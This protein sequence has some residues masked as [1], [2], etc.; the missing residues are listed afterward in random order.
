MT[1]IVTHKKDSNGFTL[2]LG[3]SAYRKQSAADNSLVT[4]KLCIKKIAP[5]Y[6]MAMEAVSKVFSALLPEKKRFNL[7]DKLLVVR[8]MTDFK[9]KAMEIFYGD[10]V[11]CLL[12]D[13]IAQAL[14]AE[15]AR[16]V[17]DAE[18]C[19]PPDEGG[20]SNFSEAANL[21]F[22]LCR[23]SILEKIRKLAPKKEGGG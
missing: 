11:D 18:K 5:R 4:C 20:N 15:Y 16:G 8:Q 10:P 7:I 13:L 3:E 6:E 22:S 12:T 23:K 21:G 14:E 1:K 9:A 17:E 19:V 2:C